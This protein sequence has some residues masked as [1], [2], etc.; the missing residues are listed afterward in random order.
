M[1]L[2]TLS[3][4]CLQ[5]VKLSSVAMSKPLTRRTL[6]VYL[7]NMYGMRCMCLAIWRGKDFFLSLQSLRRLPIMCIVFWFNVYAII[8]VF[9]F[10]ITFVFF[11][12][13]LCSILY[14]SENFWVGRRFC[15]WLHSPN[16]FSNT[17]LIFRAY[18]VSPAYH[19]L[20]AKVEPGILIKIDHCVYLTSV[21]YRKWTLWLL[22]SSVL[23]MSFI[24]FSLDF[25]KVNMELSSLV[26]EPVCIDKKSVWQYD[27]T[28][29]KTD[30]QNGFIMWVFNNR[31][32]LLW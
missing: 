23:K 13:C 27:C 9:S 31:S 6:T 19:I 16:S 25:Y 15:F 12:Y 29:L 10:S 21:V 18:F 30:H 3:V 5:F 28:W 1:K 17:Q 11:F 24:V 4:T 7:E 26:T 20:M 32:F 2:R 14:Y 8:K 22:V